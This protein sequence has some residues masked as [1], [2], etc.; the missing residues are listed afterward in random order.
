MMSTQEY[1]STHVRK[2][3]KVSLSLQINRSCK[4]KQQNTR[5]MWL[6][7]QDKR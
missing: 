5:A 2:K 7:L 1:S 3:Q 4:V 6:G